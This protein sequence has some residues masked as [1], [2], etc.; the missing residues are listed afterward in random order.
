[1]AE[2]NYKPM[3][4]LMSTQ[5]SQVLKRQD[6]QDVQLRE[7]HKKLDT[8][9]ALETQ[10]Q[11]AIVFSEGP[12]VPSNDADEENEWL[13]DLFHAWCCGLRF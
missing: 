7:M 3:L 8:A 12:V 1:M 2:P 4:E 11:Q 6:E 9:I 10:Y 5:I 13:K